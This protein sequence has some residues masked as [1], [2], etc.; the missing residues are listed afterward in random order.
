MITMTLGGL[1]HG[2]AWTFVMWGVYQGAILVV[3]HQIGQLGRRLGWSLPKGLTA[4]RVLLVLSC[5]T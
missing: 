4:S 1:W 3:D 5:S 2:A